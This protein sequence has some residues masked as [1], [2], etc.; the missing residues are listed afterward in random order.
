MAKHDE[1]RRKFLVGAAMGAGAV[2]TGGLPKDALAQ[3][4]ALSH[5]E[6]IGQAAGHD[7]ASMG[8]L[9]AFFNQDDAATI[10]AFTERLMPGVSASLGPDPSPPV[11]AGVAWCLP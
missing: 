11:R 3:S 7:N 1:A 2:A 9:G 5:P 6:T 10:S 8:G 4:D